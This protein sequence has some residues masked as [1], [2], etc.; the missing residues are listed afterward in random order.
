MP[1]L[2]TCQALSCPPEQTLMIGDSIYD[3]QAAHAAG[4]PLVLVTYGYHQSSPLASLGA[5]QCVDRLDALSFDT[6]TSS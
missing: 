1:L 6:L 5:L 2:M 4:C 3:A